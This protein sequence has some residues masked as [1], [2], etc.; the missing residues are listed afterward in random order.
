MATV[1]EIAKKTLKLELDAGIIDGK[2]KLASKVFTNVKT[3]ATDENMHMSGVVL[4]GLQSRNLLKVK[5]IEEYEFN[6]Q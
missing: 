1:A 2:Q 4:A 6:E 5:K 3:E